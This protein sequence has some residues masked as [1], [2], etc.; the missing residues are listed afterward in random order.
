MEKAAVPATV[1]TE[2]KSKKPHE[3][4]IVMLSDGVFAIAMTLLILDIKLPESLS[5]AAVGDALG[6]LVPKFTSYIISFFVIAAYWLTH[7]RIIGYLKHIDNSFITLNL[8]FL[9]FVTALPIPTGFVG[10]HGNAWQ[11]VIIY[12]L[13]LAACGLVLAAM[14]GYALWNHKLVD[15]DL[16]PKEIR[17][18]L[19][20]VFTGPVLFL[21]SLM[22]LLFPTDPSNIYY[23]WLSFPVIA[24]ILRRFLRGKKPQKAKE[25]EN[26]NAGQKD[27][28]VGTP[29]L[30][31]KN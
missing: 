31:T 25:Q 28:V 2:E 5:D 17:R 10:Q 11:V 22:I 1:D 3:D 12:T 19:I 18:I 9:F 14:W 27:E 23:T 21:L 15:S 30:D 16:A 29:V 6:G 4:R 24:F 7:R 13:N 8:L 26:H 20:G